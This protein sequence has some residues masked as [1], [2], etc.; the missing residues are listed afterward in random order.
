MTAKSENEQ[1]TTEVSTRRRRKK[2]LV[3]EHFTVEAVAG[4]C[5]RACCKRCKQTFAYSTGKKV[6]GTS[7]LKRHLTRGT[8][9]KNQLQQDK[10]QLTPYTPMTKSDGTATEQPKRRY[11]RSVSFPGI[12]FDQDQSRLDLAKMIIMHDYPLHMVEHYGFVSFVQSLQPQFKML[13]CA[14]LEDD[15]L[16]IYHREKQGVMQLLGTIP[17]R[18]C[19]A[20]ELW[21]SSQTLEYMCLTGHFIDNDWKLNRRV[22]NVIVVPSR[23]GGALADGIATCLMDWSIENKLCAVTLDNC[24]LNDDIGS[25]LKDNLSSKNLI[26][27]N[28]QLHIASCYAHILNITVQEGLKAIHEIIYVVRESIK[29]VKASQVHEDKFAEIAEQIQINSTKTLSIDVPTQWNTTY[30][31]L[32]SALEYKEAFFYLATCD[33]SYNQ[34]LSVDEWKKVDALCKYLKVLYD[35]ANVFKGMARPTANIYF[36]EAWKIKLELSTAAVSED[37]FVS[38]VIRPMHEKFDKYWKECSLILAVAVVMDPRFK[39]KL[40]EFSYSKIYGDNAGDYIKIVHDGLHELYLD[41][42]AQPLPL[43]PAYEEQGPTTNAVEGTLL[44]SD[45][46]LLDFDVYISETSSNQQTKSELDQYLEEAVLPRVY[47]FD[48]LNWWKLNKVKY[49]TLS[50]M[51]RDILSIPMSTLTSESMFSTGSR[52]LDDHHS[53]LRPETVQSIICAR[54]WLQQPEETSE[55]SNAIVKVEY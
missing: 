37:A 43:T 14:T 46:G 22:L 5:A 39:M 33:S 24:S 4:G 8:C 38:T 20:V 47:E 48:V 49:P 18:I 30:Q 21:T 12:M 51:A 2:S 6:L 36:H 13:S 35:A 40:I 7:H 32:V 50:K 53:S 42:V 15:I 28:G 52:V 23:T 27:P 10:N 11:R 55:P 9:P 44:C 1:G 29:Y 16:T 31:M 34:S 26:L 17:G 45:D 54:D 25:T 41:Y 3:W 19:L